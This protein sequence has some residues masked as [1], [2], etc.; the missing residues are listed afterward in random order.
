MK[1]KKLIYLLVKVAI[2]IVMYLLLVNTEAMLDIE[3]TFI[4]TVPRQIWLLIAI[5]C[6]VASGDLIIRYT[7][8]KLF[9]LIVTYTLLLL[10]MLFIRIQYADNRIADKFY[11]KL[12]WE[13]IV[14]NKIVFVNIIGNIVLFIPLGIIIKCIKFSKNFYKYVIV[15]LIVISLEIIQWVTKRGVFDITDIILNVCGSYLGFLF[16]TT[17]KN[18]EEE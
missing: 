15:I 1:N 8:C 13:Y 2:V 11:L 3:Q 16:I 4:N 14:K 6:L 12:W 5:M 18:D 9:V 17:P 7:P 10:V